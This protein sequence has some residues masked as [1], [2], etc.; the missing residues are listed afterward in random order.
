[1]ILLA[2][3]STTRLLV[4]RLPLHRTFLVCDQYFNLIDAW[5]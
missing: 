5:Y 3:F 1:M 4:S 2:W